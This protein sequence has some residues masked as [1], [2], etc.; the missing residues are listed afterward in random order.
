MRF[1]AHRTSSKRGNLSPVASLRGEAGC[2]F[3]AQP[4]FV[5]IELIIALAIIGI[6][7]AGVVGSVYQLLAASKQ[8]NDQQYVVTQL[9]TAELWISRDAMMAVRLTQTGSPLRFAWDIVDGTPEVEVTYYL[10]AMASGSRLRREVNRVGVL[11]TL[12]I[13]E[14]INAD[15]SSYLYTPYELTV[16]LSATSGGYTDTCTFEVQPRTTAVE[17]IA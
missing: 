2:A 12:I 10:D 17:I 13:A 7:A 14:G 16:T 8:A 4:G 1:I 9:R 5:L 15:E 3:G 11:E 6:I